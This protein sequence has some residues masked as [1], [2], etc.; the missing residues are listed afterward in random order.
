MVLIARERYIAIMMLTLFG[1]G[2]LASFIDLLTYFF[3]QHRDTLRIP[4]LL[5]D[6]C[7]L[8]QGCLLPGLDPLTYMLANA[9]VASYI[10]AGITNFMFAEINVYKSF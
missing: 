1:K 7:F 3:G 5:F 10:T 2:L 6:L 4:I 8:C 9:I